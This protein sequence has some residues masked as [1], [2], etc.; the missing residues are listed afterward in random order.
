MKIRNLKQLNKTKK[1]NN[2][3][4][5]IINSFKDKLSILQ[6][7]SDKIEVINPKSFRNKK[8][9]I[10]KISRI[11]SQLNHYQSKFTKNEYAM[12]EYSLRRKER[13]LNK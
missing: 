13:R 10:L 3:L 8:K 4:T 6:N 1:E 2:D 7:E 5:K 11:N 9:A 12:Y